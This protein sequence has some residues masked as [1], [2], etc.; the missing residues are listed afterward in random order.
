MGPGMF[1][2]LLHRLGPRLGKNDTWYRKA[3]N[4]SLKLALTL[5]FLATG[6]SCRTLVYGFRVAHNTISLFV[7]DVWQA[8]IEEYAKDAIASATTPEE[9]Q[10]IA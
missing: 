6:D 9:W 3:L 10:E 8:I 2:E 7:H 5:R 4:P 1:R